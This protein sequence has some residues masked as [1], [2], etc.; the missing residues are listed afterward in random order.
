MSHNTY[1]KLWADGRTVLNDAATVD[2]FLQNEPHQADVAVFHKAVSEVYY[3]YIVAANKLQ[4]AY[5][6]IVHPQK[7][8]LIRKLLDG[9]LCRMLE[10]KADLEL[11]DMSEHS[12][13]DDVLIKLRLSPIEAEL[14]VP[15]YFRNNRLDDIKY[16]REFIEN[17]LQSLGYEEIENRKIQLTELEAIKIIQ[18][19]ERARQG[20]LR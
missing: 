19:H 9:S 18:I 3:K 4:Q 11:C 7:R 10:L 2:N 12:Y 20:R 13:N 6:Q 16:K 5:D 17:T 1:N 15:Q 14:K 8:L